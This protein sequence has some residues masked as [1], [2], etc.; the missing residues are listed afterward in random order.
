MSMYNLLHG[1]NPSAF[2]FLP[3][4]GKHP[5]EFPR[6]RDCF[7]KD[8]D[9]PEYEGKLHILTRTGGGNR[10]SYIDENQ[11]IRD[12]PGFIADYDAEFDSTYAFWIIDIPEQWA[13]DVRNLF[14]VEG[15][16]S[17]EY[18]E[19]CASVYPKVADEIRKN[20]K[21]F[22]DRMKELNNDSQS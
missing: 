14:E 1:V 11:A 6:F 7:L 19:Q 12:I 16:V 10:S 18:I 4:L 20:L 8:D 17:E 2:Y 3:V 9:H 15:P 5:D 21:A 13:A 22:N